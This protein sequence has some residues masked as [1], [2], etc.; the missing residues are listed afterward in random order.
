MIDIHAHILPG[1]DDG[2]FDFNQSLEM[3][4]K[5]VKD[6]IRGVVCTSHVLNRLDGEIEKKFIETF[7]K[8]EYQVKMNKISISLWL[9][10]EIHCHASFDKKSRLTTLNGNGKYILL[11]LPMMEVPRDSRELFFDLILKGFTPILA[12]PERNLTIQ[13]NPEIANDFVQ[14]GVLLQVN[15]GSLTGMFG[16]K[17]KQTA[18]KMMQQQIVHFIAS[19]C[20]NTKSRPLALKRAYSAVAR[21]WGEDTARLLFQVNPYKAVI[22]EE[23]T[24]QHA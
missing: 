24:P 12:H 23:I 19:D 20:H 18:F 5:G 11:E 14:R 22:G 16:R 4:R 9:G 21:K 6:G 15:S 7:K 8:L 17:V 3:L 13:K 2:P 10:S 1:I